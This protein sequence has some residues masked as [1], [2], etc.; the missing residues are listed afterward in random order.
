MESLDPIFRTRWLVSEG[1]DLLH[2]LDDNGNG[3]PSPK[4]LASKAFR[5]LADW[6]SS[7][8]KE[9]LAFRKR[10][11][12]RFPDP[13]KWLWTE[14]SIS[15]A[16]DWWS[17]NWKASLFPEKCKT[18]DACSGAGVDLVALAL[19]TNARGLDS[20]EQA[21]LLCRRNAQSHALE[22]PISAK[23]FSPQALESSD[24]LHIDP[25]RRP[26]GKRTT[27]LDE[28]SPTLQQIAAA[29][30]RVQ[31]AMVKLAP[32]TL[33]DDSAHYLNLEDTQRLWLGNHGECKQQLLLWGGLRERLQ[34]AHAVA[35]NQR[36]AVLL[37]APPASGPAESGRDESS[38]T[39]A[40][41][42]MF[43]GEVKIGQATDTPQR[44][45]YDLHSVLH[46]SELQQTWAQ[47]NGLVALSNWKGFYTSDKSLDSTWCQRFRV[48]EVIAWDDRKVRKRLRQLK[49]GAV[50]VK[51]R[52]IRMDAN[53][54]QRRYS[55]PSN[56]FSRT[57]LVTRIADRT[58]AIIAERETNASQLASSNHAS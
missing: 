47:A 6:Q 42:T 49:I 37:S 27:R 2:E 23:V 48:D 10:A 39:A 52:L 35:H 29:G 12:R 36:V 40:S 22:P 15:Q 1:A 34:A 5:N 50:E 55:D 51:N 25:D 21:V 30:S 24:W 11:K 13:T 19:R 26:S 16:S 57:L 46:A 20:D 4:S 58:R 8:L 33:F 31:G 17:A 28:F 3:T 43:A 54:F 14:K 7:L 9:Q 44:Y 41:V 53:A 45:I 32:Q 56:E 38:R 18:L